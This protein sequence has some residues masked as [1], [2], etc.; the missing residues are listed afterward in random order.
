MK[1]SVNH[2]WK[3]DPWVVPYLAG[4]LQMIASLGVEICNFVSIL[5]HFEVIDIVM[6]FMT[7][8]VISNFGLFFY[9]AYEE[10]EWKAVITHP[11][12]VDFL[13]IQTTTSLQAQGKINKIEPQICEF[14]MKD[15]MKKA[16]CYDPENKIEIPID[17]IH[18]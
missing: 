15:N 17:R 14:I 12:Y 10:P 16:A 2:W 11:K 7:L 6:K 8:M 9:E 1:Y 3:F 5:T 4:F 13:R 18:I